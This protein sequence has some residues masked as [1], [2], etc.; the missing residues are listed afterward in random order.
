[1]IIYPT[2]NMVLTGDDIRALLKTFG[3]EENSGDETGVQNIIED[4][5][6]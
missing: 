6:E 4:L 2:I 5:S 3:E 1:M